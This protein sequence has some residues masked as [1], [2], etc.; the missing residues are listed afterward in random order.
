MIEKRFDFAARF[1]N[2]AMKIN[3]TK[4]DSRKYFEIALKKIN[5]AIEKPLGIQIETTSL[6]NAKCVFCPH[7]DMSRKKGC[8]SDDLFKKVIDQLIQIDP[9]EVYPF[10]TG[11]PFMDKKIIDRIKLINQKLPFASV[12]IFTNAAL[13]S[14]EIIEELNKLN[15]EGIVVSFNGATKKTY[16]Q[17]MKLNYETSL[18]KVNLLIQ[19]SKAPII[20]SNIATPETIP[21]E[22][23]YK[24]LWSKKKV[25]TYFFRFKNWGG[26]IKS[27]LPLTY[28]PCGR[29]FTHMA[30]LSDGRVSLCCM[31]S[32]GEVI[33]GDSNKDKLINIWNNDKAR[34]IRKFHTDGEKHKI[35]ICKDCTS[36]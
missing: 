16:E 4:Q 9:I 24:E 34:E 31:D 11:E 28:E 22:K 10:M 33:L 25:N 12:K 29:V 36:A 32:E 23:E 17:Q 19:K 13:I 1:L 21:E 6:C 26:K 2:R 7:K 18:E 30:I 14:T 3:P 15:I 20:I 35:N 8:M 5:Y 27:E